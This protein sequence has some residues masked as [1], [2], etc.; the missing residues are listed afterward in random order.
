M[1]RVTVFLVRLA[2]VAAVAAAAT[3]GVT[4][5]AG[6]G[7][8]ATGKTPKAAAAAAPALPLVVPD[9]RKL[10]FVFAKEMLEDSGLAWRVRGS[11]HGYPA[12]TVVAQSPAP[13]VRL[14]DNG[15]PTIVLTLSRTK[16]YPQTGQPADRSP[17]AAS[18]A[19]LADH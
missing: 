1:K 16:G 14:R 19:V 5:A 4:W 7:V 2:A 10:A 13:G 18:R 15:A 8:P 6:Q 17:Y 12:N 9:V 3:A 11:V